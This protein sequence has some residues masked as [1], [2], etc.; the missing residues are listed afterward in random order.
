MYTNYKQL[1]LSI[2]EYNGFRQ[3]AKLER[4]KAWMLMAIFWLNNRR[5]IGVECTN[6]V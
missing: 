3:N 6:G 2:L 5:I 1:G 4:E